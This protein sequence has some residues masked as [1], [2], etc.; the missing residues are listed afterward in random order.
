MRGQSTPVREGVSPSRQSRLMQSEQDLTAARIAA[1]CHGIITLDDARRAG[2]TKGQIDRRVARG[3]WVL[4]HEGVFRIAGAP[5][6]WRSELRAAA[7]AGGR[8]AAIS[9]RSG[10]ALFELPGGRDDLIELSCIRWRR[11]QKPGLVVHESRR[12]DDRDVTLIDG[13]P[14]TTPERTILDLASCYPH[15]RFLEYVVQAARRKRLITYESMRATFDRHAR[16]GLKGVAALRVTLDRWDP[17]SRP[18]ES[19]METMLLDALRRNGLPEPTLQ[20]EAR[21]SNDRFLGRVD[22]AYPHARVAIE[23]DSKQEHSDE[24]QLASDARR[25]RALQAR[26]DWKVLSARHEDLRRGGAELC[27]DIRIALR[28]AEPA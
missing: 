9:H 21:D 6:T 3:S 20:Y 28:R 7:A 18:T 24:F 23:Y 5:A 14:V 11:T 25:N 12:L 22:A 17:A 4:V 27:A 8:G 26:G 2:L 1:A 10:G 16:R 19:E 13:I 15:D